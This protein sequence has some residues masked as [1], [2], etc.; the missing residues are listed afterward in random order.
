MTVQIE[1]EAS[2]ATD[3]A[4]DKPST[5]HCLPLEVSSEESSSKLE[6]LDTINEETESSHGPDRLFGPHPETSGDLLLKPKLGELGKG[7][8]YKT[9]ESSAPGSDH[10][11]EPGSGNEAD[12]ETGVESEVDGEETVHT[13]KTLELDSV[14]ANEVS[15][16]SGGEGGEQDDEAKPI[17]EQ[18][19]QHT[20]AE[21][22]SQLS[23]EPPKES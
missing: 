4:D 12:V 16:E 22:D 6:P 15:A 19:A 2:E 21:Q 11:T 9:G 10:G 7:S 3:D 8:S 14:E 23:Q 20:E 13:P 18:S 5:E 1:P 17:D